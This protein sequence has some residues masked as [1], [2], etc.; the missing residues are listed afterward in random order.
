MLMIGSIDV[1]QRLRTETEVDKAIK[2]IEAWLIATGMKAS[3]LGLL[4]CANAR[5]VDRV[6][7]GSASIDSLRALLI[8][9]K[10]HPSK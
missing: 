9:V 4:A 8:Y 6:R 1:G 10:D 7:A 2:E 3:R 5:A